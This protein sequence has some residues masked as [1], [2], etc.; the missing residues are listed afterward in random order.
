MTNDSLKK[1]VSLAP[2]VPGIYTFSAKGGSASGGKEILYIGKAAN[3]KSRLRSY[4]RT[5]DARI[6]KMLSVA[7]KIEFK[8]TDSD[9]EALILESQLIKDF[10]PQFNIMLRDDKQYFYVGFS[11]ST[12]SGQAEKFPKLFLT[13][14]PQGFAGEAIGPFTDGATLKST[15]KFLRRIFPYCTCKKPHNNFCL[16]Y[17]IGKCVGFCCL[18]KPTTNN[19]QLTTYKKNI[20]AIKE[21]L[22]GKRLSLV[23]KLEKEMEQLAKKSELEKA[24]ELRNKIS[25]LKRIFENARVIQTYDTSKHHKLSLLS[26]LKKVLGLRKI[27]TRIEG[28]DISNIQGTNATGSMVVFEDGVPNKSQY[29]KFKIRSKRTPDD[30]FMLSEMLQRR[31]NHPE[32]QFPDLILI[33]GGKGQ[34]NTA[35]EIIKLSGKKNPIISVAKGRYEIFSTTLEKPVSMANLP[36]NVRNLIKNIDAEAH[37]FAINYYRKLHKRTLLS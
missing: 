5:N 33:D 22:N 18:K 28:Y 30:T 37:R 6:Q 16:N 7:E 35:R 4:L 3:L 21:I 12:S 23:K 8:K 34:L 20:T 32:W 2:S 26:D 9:I 27:P 29:R 10:R 17:H 36:S 24:I 19:L 13:H 11:H 31:F 14:Q 1:S 25:N 15:L